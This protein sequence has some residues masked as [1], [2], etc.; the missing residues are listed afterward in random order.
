M[1]RRHIWCQH[2]DL[3][4]TNTSEEEE[5]QP[6]SSEAANKSYGVARYMKTPTCNS[7]SFNSV[8]NSAF[9]PLKR[10][11]KIIASMG[12]SCSICSAEESWQCLIP[13]CSEKYSDELIVAMQMIKERSKK[14]N[15]HG[16]ESPALT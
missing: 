7:T 12:N 15:E 9:I 4:D 13:S 14:L 11:K 6:D 1:G 3:N 10:R 2:P 5:L 16:E 8:T